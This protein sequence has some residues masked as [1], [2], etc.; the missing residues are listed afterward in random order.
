MRV[1]ILSC[2]T[3][4]GHNSA[5]LAIRE[6][7]QRKRIDCEMADALSFG[8]PVY[9]QI[10]TK[11]H[12]FVY[13]NM[14]RLFGLGYRFEERCHPEGHKSMI[15]RTNAGYADKLYRYILEH[16]YDTVICVHIFAASAMTEIRRK[17]HPPLK[18]YFVA[19]DYT[20]SPGVSDLEM[21]AFFIPHEKLTDEFCRNGLP[22]AALVP[23]GIPVR[24][25]FYRKTDRRS[26]RRQLGLSEY[27]PLALLMCGSMGAGPV[28]RIAARLAAKLPENASL[29]VICGNNRMLQTELLRTI[30]S[31]QVRILG[32][33]TQ[34]PLYMDAADVLLTK[35]GG[36]SATE[37]AVKRLPILFMDAVPGCET[38]N[39]EFFLGN[40]YADTRD[41]VRELTDLA[42][43]YLRDPARGKCLTEALDAGFPRNAAEKIYAYMAASAQKMPDG[44]HTKE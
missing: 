42:C 35:A 17:Y 10:V 30:K 28:R 14:P 25:D 31:P 44:E 36:L 39:L 6:Y 27:G 8:N 1:L 13:R 12:V 24:Q 11:G 16:G 9:E 18:I 23:S 38:R 19:T 3:G 7:F 33:C 2:N 32:Y 41:T 15:Y 22:G 40:G 26:A 4:G 37:A 20:C 21:D 5:G 43:A 29:V 34:V